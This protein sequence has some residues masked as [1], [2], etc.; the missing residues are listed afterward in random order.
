MSINDP[1]ELE[2]LDRRRS[3]IVKRG[4]ETFYD[5]DRCLIEFDTAEEAI[6]WAKR[7]KGERPRLPLDFQR[8]LEI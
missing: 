3:W 8:P 7:E 1:L 4:R 6:E 2:Y 5:D